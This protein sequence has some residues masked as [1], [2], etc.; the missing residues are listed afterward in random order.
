[1]QKWRLQ[2]DP[3]VKVITIYAILVN[4]DISF[5]FRKYELK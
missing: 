2:I 1:M 5:N 3:A 4:L